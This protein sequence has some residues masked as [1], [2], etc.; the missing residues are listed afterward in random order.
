MI[1]DVITAMI[2]ILEGTTEITDL[3]GSRI[4]GL[5]IPEAQHN[6]MPR[7]AIIIQPA[8]SPG[9]GNG[10]MRIGHTRVDIQTYGETYIEGMKVFRAVYE[11]LK[12]LRRETINGTLIHDILPVGGPLQIQDPVT[13]WPF[14]NSSYLVTMAEELVT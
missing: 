7:K 14:I 3:T 11:R 10:Y 13:R 4:Y 9:R 2:G 8:G 12:H 1:P 5:E 6:G